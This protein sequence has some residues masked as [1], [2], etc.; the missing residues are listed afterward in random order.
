M[1]AANNFLYIFGQDSANV[2]SDVQVVGG[3][4]VF[5]NTNLSTGV[6]TSFPDAIVTYYRTI[7]F[8]NPSGFFGLHGT[9]AKKGSDDLDGVY[10]LFNGMTSTPPAIGAA[11]T[12]TAGLVTIYNI[13]CLAFLV[14]YADPVA[15]TRPLLCVYFDG[16]WFFCSQGANTGAGAL[17]LIAG[18][19]VAGQNKMYG[20]DSAGNLYQ[21]FSTA[22]TAVNYKWQTALWDFDEPIR[23]KQARKI[24]LGVEYSGVPITLSATMDSE[25]SSQVASLSSNAAT[26]QFVGS[27]PITFVGSGVINWLASGYQFLQGNADNFGRYIGMTFSGSAASTVFT[28]AALQ[29]EPTASWGT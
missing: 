25:A 12:V 4:T 26:I 29:Y 23:I 20:L 6:G 1:L 21:L 17:T 19:L 14:S 13:L 11:P 18:A 22:A 28:L 8:S 27:G 24:G 10:Q 2:I 5:T 7:W 16:K 9:T 3:V 15:G